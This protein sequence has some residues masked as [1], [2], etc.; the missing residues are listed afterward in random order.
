MGKKEGNLKKFEGI[1]P[2]AA[3]IVSMILGGAALY[4]GLS[5]QINLLSYK[6]DQV[7][8]VLEEHEQ[9]T[10]VE[11]QAINKLETRVTVLETRIGD[12]SANLQ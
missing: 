3:Y 4:F 7:N 10:H 1:F 2:I 8:K 12:S 9:T 11:L 5:N 6:L